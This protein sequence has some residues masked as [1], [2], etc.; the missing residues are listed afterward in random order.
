[1][2]RLNVRTVA[3]RCV[4]RRVREFATATATFLA[5]IGGLRANGVGMTASQAWCQ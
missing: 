4:V 2:T 5:G 1:M 3:K